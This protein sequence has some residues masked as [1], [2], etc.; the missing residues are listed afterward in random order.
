MG[1]LQVR[2]QPTKAPP[3]SPTH[4][5]LTRPVFDPGWKLILKEEVWVGQKE[6]RQGANNDD[7][8][9]KICFEVIGQ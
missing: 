6:E 8:T 9:R 2:P 7:F 5:D 3:V 1:W 4:L